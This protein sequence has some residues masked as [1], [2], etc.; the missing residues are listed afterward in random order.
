MQ[1]ANASD[2]D[3]GRY[4]AEAG[5]LIYATG[6]VSYDYHFATRAL[7]DSV[8]RRS[9]MTEGTLFSADSARLALEGDEL[10]G[11]CVSFPA[12][13]YRERIA[14]LDALWPDILGQGECTQEDLG[15]LIERSEHAHWLNPAMRDRIHYVHALAVK[16]EHRGKQLGVRLLSDAMELGRA[17][18]ARALE[19]DVLSDN[20]AVH[21]YASM[22]LEL[23]VESRAP[24]PE[25]FGVPPEW[26]MGIAL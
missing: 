14:A 8:V 20:P 4:A 21:F 5:D 25:A 23:L 9:W 3:F 17:A 18:R 6:P 16:P 15:G 11:L 19:L 12:P 1:L 26:R 13:Q 2:T 10:L 22:G 7:F 24:K